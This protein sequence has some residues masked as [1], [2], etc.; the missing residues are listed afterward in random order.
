MTKYK[1]KKI[2]DCRI[3]IFFFSYEYG[4]FPCQLCEEVFHHIGLQLL[5]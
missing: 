3:N 5:C 2:L 1:A 4:A